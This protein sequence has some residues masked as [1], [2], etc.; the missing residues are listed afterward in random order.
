MLQVNPVLRSIA[1]LGLLAL[2]G[3]ASL[4]DNT[5]RTESL[6]VTDT[7]D[8]RMGQLVEKRMPEHAE[9]ESGYLV[10]GSGLDAFVARAVMAQQAE[11]SI[12]TQYYMLHSDDVGTLFANELLKAANR[13]VRVRLLLDYID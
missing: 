2:G 5:Q 11:R 8:T 10:L 1:L 6:H 7:G 9:G 12:D 3:C 4:P 13:G